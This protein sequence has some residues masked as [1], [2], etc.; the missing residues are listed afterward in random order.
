MLDP[1]SPRRHGGRT[2][3]MFVRGVPGKLEGNEIDGRVRKLV[4]I[5]LKLPWLKIFSDNLGNF[6]IMLVGGQDL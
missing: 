6:Q 3:G 5:P 2:W 1:A 4:I